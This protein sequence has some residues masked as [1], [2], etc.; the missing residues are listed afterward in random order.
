M[1]KIYQSKADERYYGI[2]EVA[3]PQR[4]WLCRGAKSMTAHPNSIDAMTT[5]GALLGVEPTYTKAKAFID[6][7]ILM[8]D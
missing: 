6:M 2:V 3:T 1:F 7:L 8:E 5:R 4:A